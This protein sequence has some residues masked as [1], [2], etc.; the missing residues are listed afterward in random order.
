MAT[1]FRNTLIICTSFYIS[2][3]ALAAGDNKV[4]KSIAELLVN[5]PAEAVG[6]RYGDIGIEAQERQVYG[7]YHE[8]GLS[9]IW[10]NDAGPRQHASALLDAIGKAEEDGLDP[11]RYGYAGLGRL[12]DDRSADNLARLDL[13][14]TSSLVKWVN[15]LRHG[16]VHTHSCAGRLPFQGID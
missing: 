3:A 1:R 15:D 14:I 12:W 6:H 2:Q 10:V 11:Q 13:L 9:A 5:I 8:R 7:V 4:N 16:R